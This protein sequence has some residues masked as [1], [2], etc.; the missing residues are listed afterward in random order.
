MD[1]K[2]NKCCLKRVDEQNVLFIV[3][4]AVFY[5]HGE[6]PLIFNSTID[7]IQ[8]HCDIFPI[9]SYPSSTFTQCYKRTVHYNVQIQLAILEMKR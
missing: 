4:L 8:E 7:I 9:G 6:I 1:K 3:F 5:T 2:E